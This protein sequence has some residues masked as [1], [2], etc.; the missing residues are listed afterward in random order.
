MIIYVSFSPI[1][2]MRS[3]HLA[4]SFFS[5]TKCTKDTKK[6]KASKPFVIFVVF[7]VIKRF[8]LSESR[9]LNHRFPIT[10]SRIERTS[11]RVRHLTND[12]DNCA[13][14][15]STCIQETRTWLEI[16]IN[17]LRQIIFPTTKYTKDTKKSKPQKT[18]GIFVPLWWIT[19]FALRNS[20]PEDRPQVKVTETV[21]TVRLLFQMVHPL[22][23]VRLPPGT[24]KF[25]AENLKVCSETVA[26]TGKNH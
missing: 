10:A 25:S 18:F 5:T 13:N 21:Q 19:I 8:C 17:S 12:R 23:P 20:T 26:H 16:R 4:K 24:R 9:N 3:A 7:V 15:N 22:S 1:W 14:H 11:P 2:W 6:S